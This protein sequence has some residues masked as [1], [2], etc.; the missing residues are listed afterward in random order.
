MAKATPLSLDELNQLMYRL[1]ATL[2]VLVGH[3]GGKRVKPSSNGA[4][5]GKS[6]RG[7]KR[8]R[9][10][11]KE[12]QSEYFIPR[13]HAVDAILA[14]QQLRKQVS[15]HLLISEIR[16]IAADNLWMSPCY[17]QESVGLHF[18]WQQNWSAVSKVLPLLEA[19][20]APFNARPHWA[21]L[22][23]MPPQR[24][25]ALYE[26]L[27]NFRALVQQYDPHG[28]F[29]NTFLESALFRS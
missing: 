16:A 11:G 26:N 28:K 13:Q 19:K 29:R 14:I 6:A 27:P 22:F 12:L 4:S 3:G 1:Q 18:T 9:S 7:G 15:P 25:Q 21:K 10:A 8:D 5:N 2:D 20:L 24:L 17:H 23:T